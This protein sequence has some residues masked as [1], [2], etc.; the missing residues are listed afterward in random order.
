[1]FTSFFEKSKPIN[2]LL[3]GLC[4]TLYYCVVNFTSVLD[5]ISISYFF[6]KLGLLVVYLLLMILVNFIV[7]RN[8]VNKRNTYAVLLFALLTIWFPDILRNGKILISGFF[9]LLAIRRI[10]SLKSGLDTKKKIFDASFW[11]CLGSLFFEWSLLFLILV[12]LAVLFYA[13]N[14]YRNWLVPFVAIATVFM[15]ATCFSLLFLNSFFGL[16]HFFPV[17]NWDFETFSSW[18]KLIPLVAISVFSLAAVT[19]YMFLIQNA[20]STMKSSMILILGI[21][22]VGVLVAL[23]SAT[24]IQGEVLFFIIPTAII[25]ANYFQTEGKKRLKNILLLLLVLLT[26]FFPFI[27]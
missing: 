9:V 12:F 27:S 6:E 17:P 26:L 24:K 14:D 7:K 23:C 20:S 21:W 25:G 22:V 19:H 15:L 8:R 3:V 11:I 16:E 5:A 4:M 13:A 1:M 10:I 18:P 2:F